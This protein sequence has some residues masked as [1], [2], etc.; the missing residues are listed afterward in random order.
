MSRTVSLAFRTRADL[1]EELEAL[2]KATDRSKSWHIEQ[3]L[4]AY[5]EYERDVTEK[6]KEGLADIEAGRTVPHEEVV[7]WLESLGTDH[8]LPMPQSRGRDAVKKR[9]RNSR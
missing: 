4:E 1:N 9:A 6:I 2:A 8:E 5:L 7:A 3:A